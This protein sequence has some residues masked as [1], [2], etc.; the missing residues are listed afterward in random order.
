MKGQTL[1]L[2]AFACGFVAASAWAIHLRQQSRRYFEELSAA[3]AALHE[4]QIAME[5]DA[6]AD[7][8]RAP[9]SGLSSR[10]RV[11]DALKPDS[12]STR[13][14]NSEPNVSPTNLAVAVAPPGGGRSADDRQPRSS[15]LESL[16][17]QDPQRY[18][19]LQKQRQEAQE[20]AQNAFAKKADY[21]LNRDTSHMSDGELADYNRLL[22][23]LDQT[24]QLA[25]ALQAAELP[26]DQR[27]EVMGT[28]RSNMVELAPLLVD[29]RNREFQDYALA[30]GVR[31]A[32]APAIVTNLNTVIEA[33]SVQ[34]LFSGL[35]R[36]GPFGRGGGP[37][38]D[39]NQPRTTTPPSR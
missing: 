22:T 17:Q 31:P 15:W 23:L 18:A 3:K 1:A 19:E 34:N 30:L 39:P 13:I 8:R 24:W 29:E 38:G 36:G 14:A 10:R 7:D 20:T 6:A 9:R 27:R 37:S 32:D 26:R 35:M 33:T 2:V 11:S 4:K 12:E 28:V 21:F 25:T 16:K 5:T